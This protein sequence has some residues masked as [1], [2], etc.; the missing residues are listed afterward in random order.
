MTDNGPQAQPVLA[1]SPETGELPPIPRDRP[2]PVRRKRIRPVRLTIKVLLMAA[3]VYFLV[4]PL[5][6]GL[7]DALTDLNQV[8]PIYLFLGVGLQL[9]CWFCYA[10]LTRSALGEAG[11]QISP[12]RMFRIQMSTKALGNIV[13]GGSAAGSALGYRLL[14]LSG[15]S[16]PDA[17]FALATAGLGSAVVLNLIFWLSLLVSIPIRGVNPLYASVALVGLGMMAIVALLVVGLQHGQGRAETFLRFLARRFHFDGDRAAAALRQVGTRLEDLVADRQLLKRVVLWASLNWLLDAASLWVFVWAF[18][19][20]LDIDALLVAFGLANVAAVIPITPGGLGIVEGIYIPTLVGF[21]LSNQ[22]ATL[23]V[24]AYRL[25]QFWFPILFGGLIYASLR[26]G[27]WS[28][29]RRERLDRLRDIAQRENDESERRIDF[30]LRHW[31]RLHPTES[32]DT[33]VA[34]EDDTA[35]G[36]LKD[37]PGGGGDDTAGGRTDDTAEKPADR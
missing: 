4:I 15:V 35:E 30:A 37:T 31:P 5:I 8:R 32:G 9:V 21:G 23:G 12:M 18:G 24:A 10:L 27:P 6:P 26:V 11:K 17:G 34:D 36:A 2:H 22:T 33:L 16:G 29:E 13:P 7:R 28:I 1:G 25:A 20:T 19:G 3:V 14:T